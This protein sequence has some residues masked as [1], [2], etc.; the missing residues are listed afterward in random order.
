MRLEDIK[1]CHVCNSSN[2]TPLLN[3]PVPDI[4]TDEETIRTVLICD[5]CD[6]MHYIEDSQVSYEFSCKVN[7]SLYTPK[8][9][10]KVKDE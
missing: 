7:D 2:L 10:I 1:F 5:S 9:E 6:T 8:K 3:I 4:I